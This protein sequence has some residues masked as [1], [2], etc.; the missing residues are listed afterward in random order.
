MSGLVGFLPIDL[1]IHESLGGHTIAKHIAKSDTWLMSRVTSD[2]TIPY[3]SSFTDLHTATWAVN[4]AM[5]DNDIA[6][7]SW[8]NSAATQA[9]FDQDAAIHIGRC[10]T[11]TQPFGPANPFNVIR[12]RVILRKLRP[13]GRF[14]VLTSFPVP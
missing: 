10:A 5:Y 13:N 11:S 12:L 1:A 8:L 9:S 14:F 7:D 3:A 4:R 2:P 6:I